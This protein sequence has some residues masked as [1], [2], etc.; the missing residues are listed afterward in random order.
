MLHAEQLFPPELQVEAFTFGSVPL[1]TYLPDGDV[2]ISVF[3]LLSGH[4]DVLKNNWWTQLYPFLL[5]E[6]ARKDAA[7]RIT[8]CQ[9][10][11]ATEV[12][13]VKCVVAD[14]VVDI[15]LNAFG[16]ICTVAFLEWVD[17]TIGRAHL[18][19]RSIVLIKA[20]CYYESR[21]L[22]AHHG[23]ISSYALETMVLYVFNMHGA[24]LA[25]P[26]EV[27]QKFLDVF[28]AFD[29]DRYCLSIVGPIELASFPEPRSK[30]Q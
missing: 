12:K 7:F 23:L 3:A 30:A 25:S 21:L 20:W 15:S 24:A 10:I 29:W 18:F 2:D 17:R 27:L 22:G 6:A 4:N 9:A 19:K 28:A 26:L 13:L 11:T 14:V 16:G 1:H 8:D 5:K